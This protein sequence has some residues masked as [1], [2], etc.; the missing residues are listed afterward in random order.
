M[1][2]IPEKEILFNRYYAGEMDKQELT[3]LVK[4]LLV[5]KELREWFTVQME[6]FTLFRDP[7]KHP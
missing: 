7:R 4:R 1:N 6:F 3:D 5:D 2:S